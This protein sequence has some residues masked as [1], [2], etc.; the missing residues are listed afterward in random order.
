MDNIVRSLKNVPKEIQEK[1]VAHFTKADRAYGAG[2]ARALGLAYVSS[3]PLQR[4]HGSGKL[5][6][7]MEV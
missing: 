3:K 5:E 2:V 7:S 4:Q 1:M 6:G